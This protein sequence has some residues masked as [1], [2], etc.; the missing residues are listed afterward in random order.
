MI[1]RFQNKNVLDLYESDLRVAVSKYKFA[2]HIIERY[3]L[4]IGQLIDAPDLKL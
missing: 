4:R 2:K 3:R 1:V